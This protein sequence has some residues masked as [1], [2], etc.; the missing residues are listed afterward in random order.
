MC[1]NANSWV[2]MYVANTARTL[3]GYGDAR[4]KCYATQPVWLL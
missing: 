1:E 2:G 4:L 3:L